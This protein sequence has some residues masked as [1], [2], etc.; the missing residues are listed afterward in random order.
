MHSLLLKQKC[1]VSEFLKLKEENNADFF[2]MVQTPELACE[3]TLQ[4]LSWGEIFLMAIGPVQ[5]V[6]AVA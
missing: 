5:F 3:L 1:C 4:V 2:K 6:C